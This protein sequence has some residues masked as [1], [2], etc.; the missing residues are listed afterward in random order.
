MRKNCSIDYSSSL[1]YLTDVNWL[2]ISC[3]VTKKVIGEQ[4]TRWLLLGAIRSSRPEVF[5]KKRV[6]RNST[7]FIGKQLRESLFFNKIAGLGPATL[8]KKNFVK[9]RRTSFYKEHL[10]WLLLSYWKFNKEVAISEFF[11]KPFHLI[12]NQKAKEQK[13]IQLTDIKQRKTGVDIFTKIENLLQ[14]EV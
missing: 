14:K 9:F 10:W 8:L 2:Y 7:K 13:V 6:K 1:P 4:Q 3:K 11:E 12:I 5:C